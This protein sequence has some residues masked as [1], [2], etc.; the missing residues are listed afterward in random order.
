M[1]DKK[2]T[3]K[4]QSATLLDN[5]KGILSE[6]KKPNPNVIA[7]LT[8]LGLEKMEI[9]QIVNNFDKLNSA[10]VYLM[11]E[12]CEEKLASAEQGLNVESFLTKLRSF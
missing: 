1:A 4:K 5:F 9:L 8:N 7:Y 12:D 6:S 2:P 10:M 3:Q 11:V